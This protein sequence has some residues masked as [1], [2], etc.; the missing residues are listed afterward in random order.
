MRGRTRAQ[1]WTRQEQAAAAAAAAAASPLR[2]ADAELSSALQQAVAQ[3][4]GGGSQST[5]ALR[6][7]SL[8]GAIESAAAAGVDAAKVGAAR[9]KLAE[10]EVEAVAR[11]KG[12][13]LSQALRRAQVGGKADLFNLARAVNEATAAG[14]DGDL[15]KAARALLGKRGDSQQQEIAR[16]QTRLEK[17]EKLAEQGEG[18]ERDTA[19]AMAAK[20][21][22][23]LERAGYSA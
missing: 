16:L 8:R 15:L 1:T 19:M 12:A 13:M 2:V 17:F 7:K 11:V 21:R 18:G 6:L 23:D 10:M 14:M 22:A 20:A 5:D 3:V 9:S 4:L